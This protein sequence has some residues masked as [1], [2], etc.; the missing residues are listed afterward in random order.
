VIG[1]EPKGNEACHKYGKVRR[2]KKTWE[3]KSG[4]GGYSSLVD[5]KL[6]RARQ[7]ETIKIKKKTRKRRG[8][9]KKIRTTNPS[10]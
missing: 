1:K 8:E 7:G 4:K 3:R 5:R 9:G 6:M 2:Q 10:E